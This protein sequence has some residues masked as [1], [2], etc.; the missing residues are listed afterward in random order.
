MFIDNYAFYEC[1]KL[2]YV[3]AEQVLSIGSVNQPGVFVNC[4]SLSSINCPNAIYI[5]GGGINYPGSFSNCGI[6]SIS[7]PKLSTIQG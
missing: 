2:E 1:K 6:T 4:T 3:N 5:A 7:L